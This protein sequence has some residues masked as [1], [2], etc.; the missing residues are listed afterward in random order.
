MLQD[1]FND[2]DQ[3]IF[4]PG[5]PPKPDAK[6]K[7]MDVS[8]EYEIIK[9]PDLTR[10]IAMEYKSMALPYDRVIRDRQIPVNK[11]DTTWSWSFNTPCKSLKGILVLLKQ[12][13][14]TYETR[15]GF[16]TCRCKGLHHHRR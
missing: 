1:G 13:S 4:S 6:Y 5:S 12:N 8:L 10:H 9:Q 15:A 16:T 7:I 11:S 2:Y 14:C 3:A